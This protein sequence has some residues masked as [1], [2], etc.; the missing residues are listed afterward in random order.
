LKNIQHLIFIL[1]IPIIVMSVPAS[2]EVQRTEPQIQ[3]TDEIQ[4]PVIDTEAVIAQESDALTGALAVPSAVPRGPQDVLRDYE[5]GMSSLS[6]QFSAKLGVL[7]QAVEKGELSRDQGE[8]ISAEQ[9][10]ASRMQFELLSALHAMLQA[11]VAHAAV[12]Q[13]QPAAAK[14]SEIVMVALPFSS[15]E[16]SPALSQYLDLSPQQVTAIEQL[17]SQERRQLKPLMDEMQATRTKLLAASG[18]PQAN[19]KE[20]KTLAAAQA[21]MLTKLIVANS[22][23]QA[24]LYKLLTVEQRKKLEAFK[25]SNSSELALQAGQ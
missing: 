2:S 1:L 14:Q 18:H 8:N 3:R 10:Q 6:Q 12:A 9:Y 20:V 7:V 21:G 22:R 24:R 5:A 4:P 23:M 15:L 11:D 13:P 17:M 16:L 19:K 25:Q